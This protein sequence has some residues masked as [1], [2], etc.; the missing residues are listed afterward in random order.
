[1]DEISSQIDV[2]LAGQLAPQGFETRPSAKD[3]A[4]LVP[5]SLAKAEIL[6]SI[7]DPVLVLTANVQVSG[8]GRQLKVPT[9]DKQNSRFNDNRPSV[10]R[11][12]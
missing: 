11:F 2:F 3:G 5:L 6:R 8:D 4:P 12:I 10:F 9:N 1:L 7:G